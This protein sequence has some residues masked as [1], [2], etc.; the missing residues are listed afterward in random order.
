MQMEEGIDHGHIPPLAL[1]QWTD[2]LTGITLS[3]Q[4]HIEKIVAC[5]D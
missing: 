2:H 3:T 1:C 5:S 4:L